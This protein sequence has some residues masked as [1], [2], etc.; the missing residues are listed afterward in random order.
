M[1]V[2]D[3]AVDHPGRLLIRAGRPSYRAAIHVSRRPGSYCYLPGRYRVNDWQLAI[4]IVEDGET[5]ISQDVHA[6]CW[7]GDCTWRVHH[8]LP[9]VGLQSQ[10]R[11]QLAGVIA[12]VTGE[13]G[14][15]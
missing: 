6:D 2:P 12:L 8:L 13:V 14:C 15:P 9:H 3:G 5:S 1:N 7:Y 11:H 10:E 4:H